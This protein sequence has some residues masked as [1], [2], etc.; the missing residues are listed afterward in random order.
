MTICP[1]ELRSAYESGRVIPFI[2]AGVTMS[3]EWQS[4]GRHFQGISWQELVEEAV[5]QLGFESLDLARIRG[6]DLQLLEYFKLRQSGYTEAI[7][8]W[9]SRRLDASDEAIRQSIIHKELVK[10]TKCHVLYTTN[11][12]DFLE[13]VFL[14]EKK[15]VTVVTIESDM[16]VPH[17]HTE[18]VKFHGDLKHTD[19]MVL[20]ESDYERR[21]R[22]DDPLDYR[23]RADLL[24]R[25]VLFLGYSFR[26]PNVSYL[27]RIFTDQFWN[28]SNSLPGNRGF[29]TVADPSDF[30]IRMFDARRITVIPIDGERMS[31]DIADLLKQMR[32]GD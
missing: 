26:D 31:N 16:G 2:G 27:F 22:L 12:D 24:G 9:L 17:N 30:E 15:N 5:R 8:S 13:R 14:I 3:V 1:S 20:T 32:G 7:T 18:V 28:T 4:G 29:I 10:L 21:L 19:R 25:Y 6:T 23:L 11:Y